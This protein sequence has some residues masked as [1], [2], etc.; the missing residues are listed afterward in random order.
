MAFRAIN[1]EGFLEVGSNS[2]GGVCPLLGI[3]GVGVSCEGSV[4]LERL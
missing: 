4:S 1:E 2:A 3:L